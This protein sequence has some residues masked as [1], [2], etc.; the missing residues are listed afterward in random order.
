MGSLGYVGVPLAQFYLDPTCGGLAVICPLTIM[1][2]SLYQG[3]RFRWFAQ[4]GNFGATVAR[5]FGAVPAPRALTS[6]A[7][8]LGK[9]AGLPQGTPEVYLIPTDTLNAFAAGSGSGDS[10]VCVTQGLLRILSRKELAAVLA[11]EIA[12]IRN[13]DMVR[14]MHMCVMVAGFSSVL[15]MGYM[16][17]ENRLKTGGDDEGKMLPVAVAMI[18][19][20]AL[21]FTMGRMLQMWHSRCREFAAD[22]AA[23]ALTG[24]D[25]LSSALAKIEAATRPGKTCP[26]VK[27]ELNFS[28]LYIA[29]A[30]PA[31]T[32]SSNLS[33]LLHRFPS[34]KSVYNGI[35]N[36]LSSHPQ[37]ED[38]VEAILEAHQKLEST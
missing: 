9:R 33:G 11:H 12:H 26:L 32:L 29:D 21:L 25:A 38:R 31:K 1:A 28:H 13:G 5:T 35:A 34:T 14:G 6:M 37:T 19:S 2:G 30:S 8:I 7:Q 16:C 23:V 36:M 15:Q 22:E 20:G 3:L 17:L 4:K 27:Q 18:S 24:S 10:V